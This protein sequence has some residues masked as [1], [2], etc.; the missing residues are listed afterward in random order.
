[1]PQGR[2][3]WTETLIKYPYKSALF[4][5]KPCFPACFRVNFLQANVIISLCLPQKRLSYSTAGE[6]NDSFISGHKDIL[7]FFIRKFAPSTKI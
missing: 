1:M 6:Q 7:T 4:R 5:V 2:C 3:I